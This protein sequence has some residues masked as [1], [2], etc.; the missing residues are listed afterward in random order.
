MTLFPELPAAN[1][2]LRA[3]SGL[4]RIVIDEVMPDAEAF[5]L[6]ELARTTGKGMPVVHV[7]ADGQRLT[8]LADALRFA[9]PE[10]P[11]LELPAWDCLPYDRV[12]PGAD[13]AA[14]RLSALNGLAALKAKPHGAIVLATANAVLQKMPPAAQ[15][16]DAKL[17]AKAGGAL[18]MNKLVERLER[19]GFDRVATVREVSEYA[20]RGGILDLFAPAAENPVRLD[21]FGDVLET[22]REFDAASQ[23][24]LQPLREFALNPASEVELTPETIA[25]F[26]KAY[27]AAFGAPARDDA[28]YSAVS[29]GRRFAGLEHWLPL[30]HQH[31]ETLFDYLPEGLITFDHLAHQ[32]IEER[33]AQILDHYEARKKAPAAASSSMGGAPY[34]PVE[35]STLYVSPDA[36]EKLL[37]ARQCIDMTAY[38][39]P[40][41]QD[42]VVISG[43]SKKG[44][45]F[46]NER[47]DQNANVFDA[48]V[49]HINGLNMLGKSVMIAGWTAGS[50]DR[51]MQMLAEH[52]LG[53]FSTV[54]TLPEFE[55]AKPRRVACVLP[56][57]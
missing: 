35:P 4:G 53:G 8:L 1:W 43:R 23:L 12:S 50:L 38:A 17:I 40:P 48:V 2:R 27:I 22:I 36:L 49:R 46:S 26:R 13:V 51:L 31:L 42:R 10:L 19:Q 18:S 15:M 20:V 7:V 30:F 55:K 56:I 5:V 41:V 57:E 33:H 39:V 21:F 54:E 14:R 24:T 37:K 6:A 28:L 25:R 44:R 3:L 47:A 11:I 32:A 45:V 16:V 29:E 52:D 9:A 34:Q